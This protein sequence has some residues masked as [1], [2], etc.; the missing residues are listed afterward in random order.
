MYT[1]KQSVDGKTLFYANGSRI[2]KKDVPAVVLSKIKL[3]T[4][5]KKSVSPKKVVKKK[6]PSTGSVDDRKKIKKSPL[7][8]NIGKRDN[9]YWIDYAKYDASVPF[10]KS[11]LFAIVHRDPPTKDI[12]FIKGTIQKVLNIIQQLIDVERWFG[13]ILII[14]VP[15][16][17]THARLMKRYELFNLIDEDLLDILLTEVK[18]SPE[19]KPKAKTPPKKDKTPSPPKV[20]MD[21]G[22][23]RALIEE[24][25]CYHKVPLE[26]LSLILNKEFADFDT[27]MTYVFVEAPPKVRKSVWDILSG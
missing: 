9:Y 5:A 24:K 13:R 11:G 1:V 23:L 25:T 12:I 22:K 6:T 19:D 17:D 7:L 10:A 16:S 20:W 21:D 26:E 8:D 3:P 14:A 18:D 27:F 2:A 4:K 15:D